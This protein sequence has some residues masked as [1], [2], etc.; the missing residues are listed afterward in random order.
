MLSA[1]ILF[2]N[3]S[4]PCQRHYHDFQCINH[5][6]TDVRTNICEY[7]Q[8]QAIGRVSSNPGVQCTN[9]SFLNLSDYITKF[10]DC[11]KVL[12][13]YLTFIYI[14]IICLNCIYCFHLLSLG[15]W[16]FNA[17][18]YS[19]ER[20][21][22]TLVLMND[23]CSWAWS[24]IAWLYAINGQQPSTTRREEGGCVSWFFTSVYWLFVQANSPHIP[25]DR[26]RMGSKT[27]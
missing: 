7:I 23:R 10:E 25:F 11:D 2:G 18:F 24:C 15:H 21:Q 14:Y 13:I 5:K 12:H 26:S 9:D 19:H 6:L 27:R 4:N 16:I 3:A 17:D 22:S 1:H 8:Q 20:Q